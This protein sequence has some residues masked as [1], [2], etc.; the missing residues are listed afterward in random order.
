MLG[1]GLIGSSIR[2][3][4][5]LLA[6]IRRKMRAGSLWLTM[7]GCAE[8]VLATLGGL[9]GGVRWFALGW[10]VAISVTAIFVTRPLLDYLQPTK[11]SGQADAAT[12]QR[13][14]AAATAGRPYRRS[15]GRR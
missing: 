10:V 6:R 12:T 13:G 5:V 1:I 9:Y 7:G 8:L 14:F 4:Y 2:Q 3:H 11:T 15:W